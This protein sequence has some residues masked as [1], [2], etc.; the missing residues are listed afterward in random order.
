MIEDLQ[1]VPQL[2]RGCRVQTRSEEETVLL[3]PEGLL[4]LKGAGAEILG[5]VD[6]ERTVAQIV[7]A[8][9]SQYPPEAHAQIAAE[10]ASFLASLNQRSVLLFAKP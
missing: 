4:R 3:V 5:L 2:A 10:V 7:E 9:Q 6:G 1:Q 8:L